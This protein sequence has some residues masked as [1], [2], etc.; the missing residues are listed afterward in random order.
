MMSENLRGFNLIF[1]AI[2]FFFILLFP[3]AV[4]YTIAV[5]IYTSVII[6]VWLMPA[7]I[8]FSGL[9]YAALFMLESYIILKIIFNPKQKE[10]VFNIDEINPAIIYSAL[11]DIFMRLN[12]KI[13]S[14]LLIPAMFYSNLIMKVFGKHCG[15]KGLINRVIEPYLTSIGDELIMGLGVLITG[16]ELVGKKAILK[17]V[18]IGNRVTIGANSIISAG[19]VIE[20]EVVIGANSFVKKNSI[21][22]KGG[23]YAGSPAILKKRK[24]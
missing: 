15:K 8:Y 10:G 11:S 23:F 22:K 6:P 9:S 21:L 17:G 20:D 14:M 5:K 4:A 24:N 7:F 1:V 16:H 3:A 12:E 18:T 2:F 13:F 19:T